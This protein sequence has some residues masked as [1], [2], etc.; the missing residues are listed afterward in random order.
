MKRNADACTIDVPGFK[1]VCKAQPSTV[2]GFENRMFINYNNENIVKAMRCC[3]NCEYWD[4]YNEDKYRDS[5]WLADGEC[6]RYPPFVP[7]I[8]T[9]EETGVQQSE[10]VFGTPLMS[11][12]FT[13]GED[14][15]GEFK[16][17]DNP[18]TM[19]DEQQ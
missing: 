9:D 16:I 13:Y 10:T 6:H 4:C 2:S 7:N 19:D 11:H 1:D 3:A 15:C 17:M 8:F 18:R 5:I 12:V 14:W